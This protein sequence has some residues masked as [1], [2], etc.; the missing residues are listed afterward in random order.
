MF[1]GGGGG[2]RKKKIKK[3]KKEIIDKVIHKF[4]NYKSYEISNYMHKEKAYMETKDNE[5]IPFSFAKEINEF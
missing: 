4:K 1:S 2:G 5:I 3:K